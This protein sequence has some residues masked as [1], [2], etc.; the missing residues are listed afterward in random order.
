M[1]VNFPLVGIRSQESFGFG[2]VL[3]EVRMQSCGNHDESGNDH[4][5]YSLT[6]LFTFW[7]VL[8]EPEKKHNSRLFRMTFFVT[9]RDIS[10]LTLVF[11]V[12]VS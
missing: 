12:L 6:T 5:D 4:R 3:F 9:I 2:D 7:G 11:F 8:N 1:L 10:V